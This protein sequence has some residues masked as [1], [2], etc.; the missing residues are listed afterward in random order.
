MIYVDRKY[1][2]LTS[3]RLRNF[4]QKTQNLWNFSCPIC[5]DSTTNH[6]KARGYAYEHEGVLKYKCHNC[7]VSTTFGLLLKHLDPT[8]HREFVMENFKERGHGR[9]KPEPVISPMLGLTEIKIQEWVKKAL[10]AVFLPDINKLED[11]HYAKDYIIDRCIPEKHWCQI[12]Y[13]DNFKQ[14][15]DVAFP[16]HGKDKLPTDARVV[17]YYTDIDGEVT[18]V[19][20]RA[21]NATD[22]KLRYITIKV[23]PDAERKVFGVNKIN[24][25]KLIYVVEGQ[26]DSM[27]LDNALATG[28]SSLEAIGDMLRLREHDYVLV[29]DNQPRNKEIVKQMKEAIKHNHPVVLWPESEWKD[30]NDLVQKGGVSVSTVHQIIT[31]HTMRGLTAL[32]AFNDWKRT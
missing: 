14:Y 11:G 13:T 22:N 21:L 2:S 31:K 27:F 32:L 7:G 19:A 1:L 5:G 4:K 17:M 25:D 29:Y 8:L 20:G 24:W 6:L 30:I 12:Y 28:D 18:H 10:P 15:M 9:R 3:G 23:K 26:F 16:K